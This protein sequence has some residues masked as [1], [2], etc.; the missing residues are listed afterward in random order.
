MHSSLTSWLLLMLGF[1][2]RFCYLLNLA[3]LKCT[4]LLKKHDPVSCLRWMHLK[5]RRSWWCSLCP[6]P[7]GLLTCVT[8]FRIL[9][10]PHQCCW[11]CPSRDVAACPSGTCLFSSSHGAWGEPREE[12]Q[13]VEWPRGSSV[14]H[15]TALTP[16]CPITYAPSWTSGFCMNLC[17]ILPCDSVG[18]LK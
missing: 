16:L 13:C 10:S 4:L 6:G 9:L 3:F 2:G 5:S 12:A 11:G 17:S 14:P 7:L 18:H 8:C 1:G 15:S